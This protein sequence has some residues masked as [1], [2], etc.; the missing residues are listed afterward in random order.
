[1]WECGC[2]QY[3]FRG[4]FLARQPVALCIAF[5]SLSLRK[6]LHWVPYQPTVPILHPTHC[7][8]PFSMQAT[9]FAIGYTDSGQGTAAGEHK[10]NRVQGCQGKQTCSRAEQALARSFCVC[11]W[12]Q[13]LGALQ[14]Q[15]HQRSG[16]AQQ[17]QDK[18]T[19]YKG[20]CGAPRGQH[21]YHSPCRPP[22]HFL[23][24]CCTVMPPSVRP[25]AK[26]A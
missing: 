1:M 2:A 20:I 26:N 14:H 16:E 21:C 15:R 8:P 24:V 7:A 10:G 11:V 17:K 9:E 13:L 25:F 22:P 6:P 23:H 19:A 5:P 12:I 18:L 4:L 3:S